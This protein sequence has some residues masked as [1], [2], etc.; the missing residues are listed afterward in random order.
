MND[1]FALLPNETKRSA[2]ARRTLYRI[3]ALRDIGSDVKA[4]DVGGWI[5]CELNLSTFGE[6]WIYDDATCYYN[7][8]VSNNAQLRG[9]ATCY[10]GGYVCDNAVVGGSAKVIAGRVEDE[11][12]VGGQAEV[13]GNACVFGRA[14]VGG[15]TVL[16]MNALVG[17]DTVLMSSSPKYDY[18]SPVAAKRAE[19][20][21]KR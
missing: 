7:G 20:N 14:Q 12:R 19:R 11:A 1:K 5:E 4:G 13:S 16:N 3:K 21:K 9:D 6:S 18:P 10:A 2:L 15:N 17:F 8:R